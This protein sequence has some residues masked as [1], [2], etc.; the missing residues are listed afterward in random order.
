MP[1]PHD[2]LEYRNGYLQLRTTSDEGV[3]D[4]G[5]VDMDPMRYIVHRGHLLRALPDCWGGP[6]RALLFYW[7]MAAAGRSWWARGLERDSAPFLVG[8]Y[9]PAR[10]EDR[11]TMSQAFADAVQRFGLV[12]S[13]ETEVAVF[14]DL[15]SGSAG[16][17]EAFQRFCQGMCSRIVIGQTLTST[18]QAQ[19]L[20][21][22]QANVQD[23]VLTNI[24]AFDDLLLAE[25]LQEQLFI[26]LLQ[27]NG[28]AGAPPAISRGVASDGLAAR[29]GVIKEL[30]AAGISLKPEAA[31]ALSE[32]VGLPLVVDGAAQVDDAPLPGKGTAK[33][34]VN[35]VDVDRL[36]AVPPAVED[37]LA[38][39][40]AAGL[41][42]AFRGSLAPVRRLIELS[43]SAE[44]LERRIAEFYDGW[45]AARVASLTA[46]ALTAFALNGAVAF[47]R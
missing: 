2:L 33:P 29:V 23:D 13:R 40:A 31:D 12:V 27:M 37:E 20:G 21:G 42:R 26:P 45:P 35:E 8:K 22:G 6:G 11:Y 28:R 43:T 47:P 30:K 9:D 14:K 36:S 39:N 5:C 16:A 18:A 3:P 46:E 41:A 32:A 34:E 4:G 1:V 10:P 44:D 17:H 15:A 24:V 25:T 38:R 19:G 7:F